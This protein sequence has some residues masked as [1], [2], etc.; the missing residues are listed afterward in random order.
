[1]A[2]Q[3]HRTGGPQPLREHADGA[4]SW[5]VPLSG[6]PSRAWV[7]LFHTPP[8]SDSV[9]MPSRVEFRDRHIVFTSTEDQVRGWIRHIDRWITAANDGLAVD[10]T[11]ESLAR[12]RREQGIDEARQRLLDADKYRNL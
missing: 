10:E 1:M 7:T 11:R 8:D 3:I 9:C 2:A 6:L 5:L 4:F 12:E